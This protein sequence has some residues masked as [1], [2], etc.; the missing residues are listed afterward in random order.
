MET[1]SLFKKRITRFFTNESNYHRIKFYKILFDFKIGKVYE[2][3]IPGLST[4]IRPEGTILDIGANMGQW[5]MP[6]C[7]D[8]PGSTII[9]FEPVPA[10]YKFL[11]KAI[12]ILKLSNAR[13]YNLAISDTTGIEKILIPYIDNIPITTQSV[14]KSSVKDESGKKFREIETS[15]ITIDEFVRKNNIRNIT[16]MKIDTEGAEDKVLKGG[17]STILRDKP[18]MVLETE[19]TNPEVQKLI[20]AGY[21]AYYFSDMKL[22]PYYQGVPHG[23][24]ILIQTV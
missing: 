10:N 2:E 11:C 20:H 23:D 6:M 14:L 3:I 5:L 12:R 22:V 13:S 21:K 16:L 8:F 18:A 24:L 7:K 19:I 17:M 1:K 9:A 4:F 15:T